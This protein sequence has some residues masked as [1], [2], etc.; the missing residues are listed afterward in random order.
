MFEWEIADNLIRAYWSGGF[1]HRT[2]QRVASL[3]KSNLDP[4]SVT[5]VALFLLRMIE[6]MDARIRVL[7]GSRPSVKG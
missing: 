1:S 3:L 5:A 4:E 2:T 6:E 7:E